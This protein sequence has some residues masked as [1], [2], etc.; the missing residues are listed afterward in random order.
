MNL[1]EAAQENAV[2]QEMIAQAQA[3][4]E[5]GDRPGT[6]VEK[7]DTP[8]VIRSIDSAGYCDIWDTRTGEKSKTNYNMLPTQLKKRREDGSRVFTTIDPGITPHRGTV[9][10]LLHPDGENRK[11][12]DELG[13]TVCRKSNLVSLFQLEQHMKHKHKQEYATIE[14]ERADQQRAEDREFQRSIMQAAS[15][16]PPERKAAKT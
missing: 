16:H 15:G 3:A 10:C 13:F 7:G 6:V 2:I 11:H 4:A 1:Q 14:K 9:K 8:S 12:Y 5:P